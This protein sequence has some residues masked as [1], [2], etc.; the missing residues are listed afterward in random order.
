MIGFNSS[1]DAIY[2][3]N[4]WLATMTEG[5]TDAINDPK[6]YEAEFIQSLKNQY[7][8]CITDEAGLKLLFFGFVGGV[9]T[10]KAVYEA[11]LKKSEEG[12]K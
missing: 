5:Y 9:D 11:E 2:T 7:G 1:E 4:L 10:A 6:R 12:N 3:F 8:E